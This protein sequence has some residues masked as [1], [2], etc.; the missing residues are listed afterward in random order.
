MAQQYTLTRSDFDPA[1]SEW[2]HTALGTYATLDGARANI[3]DDVEMVEPPLRGL[4]QQLGGDPGDTVLI[5]ADPTSSRRYGISAEPLEARPM[6]NME[7]SLLQPGDLVLHGGTVRSV[8]SV[9]ADGTVLTVYLD[10]VAGGV[11]RS[12]DLS[13]TRQ[14]YC[15]HTAPC[16]GAAVCNYR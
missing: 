12:E 2:S 13:V 15:Q 8:R 9:S 5:S 16:S 10:G 11:D 7:F 3:P 4:M 6:N 14:P 1:T